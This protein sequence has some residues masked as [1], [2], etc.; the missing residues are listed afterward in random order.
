MT[1]FNPQT[2][3]ESGKTATGTFTELELTATNFSFKKGAI[4]TLDF[5]L[6][7]SMS[8]QIRYEPKFKK[9]QI[10]FKKSTI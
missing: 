6:E 4:K 5:E 8:S 2:S 3:Q 7:F 1:R 9:K 10:F